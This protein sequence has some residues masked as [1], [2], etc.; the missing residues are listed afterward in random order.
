MCSAA[1]AAG[2]AVCMSVRQMACLGGHLGNRALQH[3]LM[4]R[5]GCLARKLS[6]CMLPQQRILAI[7]GR[8]ASRTW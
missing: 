6:S 7:A 4:R 1:A 2:P 8:Q 5:W 3:A